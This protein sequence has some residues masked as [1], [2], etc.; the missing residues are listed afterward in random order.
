MHRIYGLIFSI[1]L[2][3]L[4]S[5]CVMILQYKFIDLSGENIVIQTEKEIDD[6]NHI[7]SRDPI[8][9]K[10]VV[11]ESEFTVYFQRSPKARNGGLEIFV[12]SPSNERLIIK[13]TEPPLNV[14]GYGSCREYS[15]S[16][17]GKIYFYDLCP[18]N[19]SRQYYIS[20]NI[21]LNNGQIVPFRVKYNL[22]N[23]GAWWAIDSL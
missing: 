8:P 5:A 21:T 2:T 3:M 9:M 6:E 4:M 13:V 16:A 12:I 22:K 7:G 15:T 1:T 23:S 17:Q 20:F 14:S 11:K 18:T 10:Y 19:L